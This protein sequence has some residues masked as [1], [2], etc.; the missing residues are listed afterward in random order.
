MCAGNEEKTRDVD[1][2]DDVELTPPSMLPQA[3]SPSHF[4]QQ[5]QRGRTSFAWK[6]SGCIMRSS[7]SSRNIGFLPELIDVALLGWT[8]HLRRH[9]FSGTREGADAFKD[10]AKAQAD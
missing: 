3:C 5:K 6:G 4:V 2:V 10:I 9:A 8:C 7:A 1:D